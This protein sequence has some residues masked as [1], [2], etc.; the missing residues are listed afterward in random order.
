MRISHVF[1]NQFS[2]IF[3]TYIIRIYR[4]ETEEDAPGRRGIHGEKR[5][6]GGNINGDVVDSAHAAADV[7]PI[8]RCKS[9]CV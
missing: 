8:P 6:A 4:V 9:H 1:L 7:F 2:L 3:I 5:G